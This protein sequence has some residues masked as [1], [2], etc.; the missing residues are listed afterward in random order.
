ML[1]IE[2]LVPKWLVGWAQ[3]DYPTYYIKRKNLYQLMYFCKTHLG[4]QYKYY[5]DCTAIDDPSKKHRFFVVYHL[6]SILYRSCL[7]IKTMSNESSPLESLVSIYPAS[8]WYEREVWDMFG[9]Y[10]WN[11]PDLRR[12]LTDYGFEGYPL[13]KDFPLSGYS[14]VYFDDGSKRVQSTGVEMDSEYRFFDFTKPW[15]KNFF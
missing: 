15:E 1:P 13:R 2:Y 5:I 8:N 3:S 14:E 7:R 10:F 11:H 12:I 9:I 6:R 4:L